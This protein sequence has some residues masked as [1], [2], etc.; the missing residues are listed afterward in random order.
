MAADDF[1]LP[2][3]VPP[4]DPG[5]LLDTAQRIR[6]TLS[7]TDP[8]SQYFGRPEAAKAAEAN[9]AAMLLRAG[10]APVSRPTSGARSPGRPGNGLDRS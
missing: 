2:T 7:T 1:T 5:P 9:V 8:A 3:S 10:P 6:A 4:V